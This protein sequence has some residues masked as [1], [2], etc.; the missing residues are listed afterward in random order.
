MR[1]VSAS[2]VMVWL[3]ASDKAESCDLYPRAEE[4]KKGDTVGWRQWYA[5][6]IW[7]WCDGRVGEKKNNKPEGDTYYQVL[8]LVSSIHCRLHA[9]QRGLEAANLHYSYRSTAFLSQ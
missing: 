7:V 8:T 4:L 2:V 1:R 6:E 3:I 9:V 5:C